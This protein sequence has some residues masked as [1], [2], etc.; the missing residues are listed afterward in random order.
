MTYEEIIKELNSYKN[1][2]DNWDG[3]GGIKP[4]D[5]IIETARNFIEILKNNNIGCPKIM[6]SGTGEIGI[7]W[8]SSTAYIEI[9]FDIKDKFTYFY[10]GNEL[11]G[12]DDL[13]VERFLES[14][15]Y[16]KL[17]KEIYD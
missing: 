8:S 5:D 3:Y 12:E 7:F 17:K 14:K 4:K 9:D 2:K 16:R 10:N 6:V 15:V 1:L 11:F 13:K